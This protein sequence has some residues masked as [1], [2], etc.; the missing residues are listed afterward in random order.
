MQ[1]SEEVTPST[2]CRK[3]RK[4][5]SFRFYTMKE[6]KKARGYKSKKKLITEEPSGVQKT[7]KYP[8]RAQKQ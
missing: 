1:E 8:K 4:K 2:S 7:L 5:T 3:R 6:L